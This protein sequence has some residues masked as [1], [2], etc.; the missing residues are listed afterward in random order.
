M[1]TKEI[2]KLLKEVDPSGETHVRAG[3]DG[4]I[5]FFE[6]KEGYW[7]GEYSYIDD[8]GNFIITS[9]GTKID[10]HTID[11]ED[12]IY[13]NKGDYSKIKL[14][15]SNYA[16]KNQM[17]EKEEHYLKEFKK[18]SD[19]YKRHEETIRELDV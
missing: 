18:I 2:I 17:K 6:M 12:F 5:T 11:Y 13:N 8:E 19:D 1:K 3:D 14:D 7:D 4:V 10:M 15:F 9:T 16:D